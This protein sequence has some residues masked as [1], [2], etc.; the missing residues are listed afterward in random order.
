MLTGATGF[1]GSHICRSLLAQ[2]HSVRALVRSPERAAAL[3]P[4]ADPAPEFIAGDITDRA[5]VERAMAGCDALVHTAAATPM[6]IESV[7]QLFAV[8]VGGT[9]NVVD[10][11]LAG[12]I[13]HIVCLSS[14]TAIFNRDGSKVTPEAEPVPSRMPYGQ[15]KVEAEHYLRELQA[16]GVPIAILYP[17]GV[18]GPDD[19]GLSDSCKA[20][21][22]RL[23]NGFRIFGDGGVQYVDVRDLADL[24][25]ALLADGAA[26]RFLV[27]GVYATWVEQ[28]DLL[29]SVSGA[30]LTRI[31]AQGWK[32]RLIGRL[33]D[34]VRL[35]RTVDTPISAETMRYATQW[36]KI[37]NTP[38]LEQHGL[39]LRPLSE[40]F[41]DTLRSMVSAG[42]LAPEQ[43]PRL[44]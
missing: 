27:P 7:D 17:G 40:T 26:G 23:E 37:A 28:A 41:E 4:G 44:D 42:H 18:L 16:R 33:V 9:R 19:P 12:G 10:T 8:N 29:E 32:L 20:I 24:A 39:T 30:T 22:H 13:E 35:F 43:C 14:I 2:G 38:A 3:F 31:P 5:V 34:I 15:S 36:P 11:A 1:V 21:K 25:C 6:Q